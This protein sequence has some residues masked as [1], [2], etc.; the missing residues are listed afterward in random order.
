MNE[1]KIIF[2]KINKTIGKEFQNYIYNG[3]VNKKEIERFV[4]KVFREYGDVIQ[5]LN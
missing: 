1:N 5:K 4:D 2:K 3:E